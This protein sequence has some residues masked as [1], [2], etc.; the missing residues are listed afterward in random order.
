MLK[1]N[2]KIIRHTKDSSPTARRMVT[3]SFVGIMGPHMKAIGK[4][5]MP[6][7][8]DHSPKMVPFTRDTLKMTS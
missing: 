5:I 1:F 2:T 8:K 3:A 4:T 7:E 6:S